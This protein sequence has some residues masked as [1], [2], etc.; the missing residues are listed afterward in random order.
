MSAANTL[1][2]SSQVSFLWL[3]ADFAFAET[4]A[5]SEPMIPVAT[6]SASSTSYTAISEVMRID[7]GQALFCLVEGAAKSRHDW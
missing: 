7:R 3:L 5:T 4:L 6:A 1:L 2:I